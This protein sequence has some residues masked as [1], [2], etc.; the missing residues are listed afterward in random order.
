MKKKL[1][2]IFFILVFVAGLSL[3]LYP[4][5]SDW[6]NKNHQSRAIIEYNKVVNTLS[7][8][9]RQALWDAAVNYNRRLYEMHHGGP[10]SEED[11]K[12]E[13]PDLLN[14]YGDGMMGIVEIPRIN[15]R[16]P[17]RHGTSEPVLQDS[18]GHV[19][20]S[21]LPVGGENTHCVVSGH[22]G[23]PSAR[24]FTDLEQM[25]VGDTFT[26]EVLGVRM[27]YVVDQILVVVP[28]KAEALQIEDGKDYC[29]LITCTPYGVN[30]HRLLVR[31][32][33]TTDSAVQTEKKDTPRVTAE[34]DAPDTELAWW[35]R[36]EKLPIYVAAGAVVLLIVLMILSSI[37]AKRRK[38][39]KLLREQEAAKAAE[40]E[41]AASETPPAEP[42]E[43]EKTDNPS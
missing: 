29:T 32:V 3:L 9:E 36:D 37:S 5:V 22:T 40:A 4:T 19:D 12:A 28:W 6:W 43:T 18:I 33:H 24:L 38:K 39:K 7:E 26:L 13:Y 27:T 1:P 23:L 31:G 42:G 21:S 25:Q 11:L 16:L 14:L 8:D 2:V 20:T 34:P 41:A 30:S 35:L 15:V 10:I 17:L